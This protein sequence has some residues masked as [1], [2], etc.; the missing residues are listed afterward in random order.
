VDALTSGVV[1]WGA[2]ER[3]FDP[4]GESGDRYLV[5]PYAD[6]ALVAVADGLGHGPDAAAAARTAMAILE[7][8]A[9]RPVTRLLQYCHEHLR[10][11]RGAALSL[12]SFNALDGTMTWLGVGNVDGVVLRAP[13]ATG[14]L[15]LVLLPGVVGHQLP[16]LRPSVVRIVPGDT[17]VLVTDGIREDFA[18]TLKAGAEVSEAADRILA[19][20]AKGTDDALVL[21]VR[22]KG[23]DS[24][25]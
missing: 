2:A 7:M 9:T 22:Y 17:L 8:D 19:G 12:A 1:E 15:G 11:T 3:P 14:S 5:K 24:N 6:G 23:G 4:L 21:V 25:P 16:P 20:H 10:P 18:E 13:P